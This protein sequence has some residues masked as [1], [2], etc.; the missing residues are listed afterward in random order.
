[1]SSNKETRACAHDVPTICY[2]ILQISACSFM[3]NQCLSK[4]LKKL[5]RNQAVKFKF[6][7]QIKTLSF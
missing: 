7:I 2:E 3:H 6:Q 1:M 5:K 4:G